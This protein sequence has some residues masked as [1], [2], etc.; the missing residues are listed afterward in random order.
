MKLRTLSDA[1]I[2]K[3]THV[4]VRIDSD[5]DVVKG[6]I[7][8][9]SAFRLD[10]ALP[11]LKYLLK[12]KAVVTV[13]GH[14]GRPQGKKV[15]ALSLAPVQKYLETKLKT[16]LQFLPNVRF[17]EREEKNDLTYARELALDNEI[18]INDSFATAHRKHAS[19]HAIT[20]V[21]PSYAG[22]QFE[23]EVRE[24]SKLLQS[25]KNLAL[26]VGGAKIETK[27]P[28]LKYFVDRAEHI[29]VVGAGANAFLAAC[30]Y[31]IGGSNADDASIA[32]AKRMLKHKNMPA[33]VD[34]M[35]GNKKSG[36]KFRAVAIEDIPTRKICG[37]DEAILDSGPAS[38]VMMS[39]MLASAKTIIWNGPA[40]VFERKPFH[41]GTERIT[42]LLSK[43]G[44]AGAHVVA[45][46][47]ETV[48]AILENKM[49]HGF[50][51]ISTGGGAMLEFLGGEKMPVVEALSGKR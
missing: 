40:G 24:L 35:V 33:V 1:P 6:K 30:G 29:F 10:S 32:F 18:F 36:K 13:M 50:A 2:F 15:A 19:T 26:I 7:S 48:T 9:E 31:D 14:R 42:R 39:E 16:K 45:G 3:G 4:L 11:T 27:L 47:G 51:H 43:L 21:L 17:D 22:L 25:K 46:G 28:R 38:I 41:L 5:V 49:Q 20:N 34:V 12:K 23:T 8:R 37:P 44:H